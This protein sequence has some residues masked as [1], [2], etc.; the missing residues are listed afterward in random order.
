MAE[1]TT[2]AV[3]AASIPDPT[4]VA[5][6]EAFTHERFIHEGEDASTALAPG[7]ARR[8][9]LDAALR[10]IDAG[11]PVP[12]TK[13]RRRYAL[14]LGLERV[15]SEDEPR[16]ADGTLLNPHQVDALSGTLV[17]LL[18]AT[19]KGAAGSDAAAAP[20]LAVDDAPAPEF[21]RDEAP[22]AEPEP[23]PDE[24]EEEQDEDDE[25][26]EEEDRT[27]VDIE[28]EGLDDLD[29]DDH[30]D[31]P[32]EEESY[33]DDTEDD[34]V[35]EDVSEEA[36]EDPNAGKRFWF[37]H[38][39]GAGKTVA[40]MGFVDATRTGGV[41]ILT[42]RRNLVDQFLGELHTRGYGHRESPPLL[43][44]EGTGRT[45]GPVTVETYQWFVRNAG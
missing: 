9:A 40:A 22:V 45:D 38:A 23:E 21:P 35:D 7:S 44:G 28:I 12:S 11:A 20:V 3:E 8:R 1:S 16:L 36:A 31:E 15:L 27:P 42:H 10:E 19:Q 13:W 29:E 30:D 32:A 41:L 43:D 34:D 4:L 18:A 17:A 6:A 25:D 24:P 39:T 26:D 14:L 37:E 33:E 5:K 2:Q